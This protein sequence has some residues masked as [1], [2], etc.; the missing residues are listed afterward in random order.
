VIALRR[1]DVA[2]LL[3]GA[4]VLL[5]AAPAGAAGATVSS[6]TL[7][8]TQ[9]NVYEPVPVRT[10]LGYISRPGGFEAANGSATPIAPAAGPT[11]NT[12]SPRGADKA[13]TWNFAST[14]GTY[15]TDTGVGEIDFDGGLEYRSVGHGITIT[16]DDP[17]ITLNGLSGSLVASGTYTGGTQQA[18]QVLPYTDQ[19]VFTLDLSKSAVILRPDGSREICGIVPTLAVTGLPFP[20]NYIGGI[21]GPD[22]TPNNF[23]SFS[24]RLK[25]NGQP[26]TPSADCIPGPKGDTGATGAPGANGAPGADGANGAPGADGANGAPGADGANG[27][28]GASGTTGAQGPKGDTGAAGVAGASAPAAIRSYV[29]YLRT[30][31]YTGRG[32]NRVTLRRGGKIVAT[33]TI[34]GRVLRVTLK[35]GAKSLAGRYVIRLSAPSKRSVSIVIG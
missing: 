13:F 27:A 20:G 4:A 15:D 12:S 10:W 1:T 23:G 5:A 9:Y 17:T 29:A 19:P 24:L 34:R 2:A 28:A 8:W 11:V 30:A 35:R 33:G 22:R 32:S 25:Q 18:P 31:P 7:S 16:I 3:S 6:S 26:A 14:T 21:S